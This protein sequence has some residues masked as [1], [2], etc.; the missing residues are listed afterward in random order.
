MNKV[1]VFNQEWQLAAEVHINESGELVHVPHF[2]GCSTEQWEAVHST[3]DLTGGQVARFA[4]GLTPAERYTVAL[5]VTRQ[6]PAYVEVVVSAFRGAGFIAKVVPAG[7]VPLLLQLS[8]EA[9]SMEERRDAIGDL[10]NLSPE[11]AEQVVHANSEL[12]TL[13]SSAVAD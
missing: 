11:Q 10:V 3:L 12:V 13:L 7:V 1:V 6:D 5:A 4:S 8:N 9:V 2:S